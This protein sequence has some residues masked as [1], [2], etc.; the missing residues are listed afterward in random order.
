VIHP[1]G[2]R[3]V[4]AEWRDAATARAPFRT[5]LRVQRRDGSVVWA[6][7]NSAAMLDGMETYGH[8]HTVEDITER[9][10]TE[11]G[12]REAEEALFAEK[13]RAQV[14]L[15]SIGDAVVTTDLHGKV[16]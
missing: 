10:S 1:E 5:D 12:L 14:T 9:K 4:F 11:R 13:E 8:V 6:R 15:N 16:T 7:V 3:R 2:R